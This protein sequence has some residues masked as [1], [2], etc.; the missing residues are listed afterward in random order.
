MLHSSIIAE[1]KA[2]YPHIAKALFDAYEKAVDKNFD[3]L[4]VERTVGIMTALSALKQDGVISIEF[5]RNF[6]T[7]V[8]HIIDTACNGVRP[9]ERNRDQEHLMY[10]MM[11]LLK[12][13]GN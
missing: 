5:A 12:T 11:N 7:D 10:M 4:Y 8:A 9:R 13:F 2:R 6:H 1:E 3:P